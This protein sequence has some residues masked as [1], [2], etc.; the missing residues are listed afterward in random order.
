M[1]FV[2]PLAAFAQKAEVQNLVFEG[3]GIRGIAYAGAIAEL[4]KK[5]VL[6]SVQRVG[7]TSA[8]AITAMLLSLGYTAAE[9]SEVIGNTNFK[10]LADGQWAFAGGISRMR[11]AFG[12]YRGKKADQWLQQLIKAKAGK[13]DITFAELAQKG[14]KDLYVT[15]TSLNRQ[16][17]IVFSHEHFPNMPVK[18][19]VRI[20]MS[21]PFYFEAVFMDSTGKLY[22]KPTDINGM[23]VMVDGGFTG[24]F[25][26]WLFDSTKYINRDSPNTFVHNP[27]TLGFRL[28]RDEQIVAD[29][30]GKDLAPMPI[31]N[32]K[33]YGLA[34]YNMLLENLNR[35]KLTNAD[36]VR[37]VSISDGGL[38]PRIR[39]LPSAE[40]AL[41]VNN[42]AKAVQ[43]Y[44]QPE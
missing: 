17:L 21:I 4:E 20:S 7:G 29:A 25:P 39:R 22:D 13:S 9:I 35:Q 16:Q 36:W 42:G 24:N 32:L 19:A 5:G 43:R 38:S 28:D 44:L 34:F 6:N 11:K 23:H 10:K 2:G 37:T 3:A 26:I 27:H 18:D 40:I 15:G 12:W 30:N 33:E 8:G 14:F 1:A 41:L 31:N